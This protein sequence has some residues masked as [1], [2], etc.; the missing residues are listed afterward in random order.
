[1]HKLEI[2]FIEYLHKLE[3]FMYRLAIIDLV[4]WNNSCSIFVKVSENYYGHDKKTGILT[5][6]LY[7]FFLYL[8]EL[9]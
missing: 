8:K 2:K 1:M 3:I 6:P 5:I 9:Q 7:S 4:T